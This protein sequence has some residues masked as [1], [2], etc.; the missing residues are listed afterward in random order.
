[1]K[2]TVTMLAFTV[3]MVSLFFV[4]CNRGETSGS[5]VPETM[6]D[7]VVAIVNNLDVRKEPKLLAQSQ[8]LRAYRL[9]GLLPNDSIKAGVLDSIAV[10]SYKV[11]QYELTRMSAQRLQELSLKRNDTLGIA[12]SHWYLALYY[13]RQSQNDSAVNN[14]F[15]AE[16]FYSLL[17]VNNMAGRANLNLAIIQKNQKDYIGSERSSIKALEF[18]E[19]REGEER[20]VASAYNNLGIVARATDKYDEALEYHNKALAVKRIIG[21]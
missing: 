6:Q 3:G 21:I 13:A 12:N 1:M 19:G 7:S 5:E 4:S 14:Y 16:R 11:S 2:S 18:L 8:L 10:K 9:H 17:G 20:I 15:Y